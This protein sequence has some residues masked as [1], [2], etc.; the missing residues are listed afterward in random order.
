M[1]LNILVSNFVDELE[2][3]FLDKDLRNLF[4]EELNEYLSIQ[5]Y[6]KDVN[7][8]GIYYII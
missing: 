3:K 1:A 4:G 6:N 5:Q 7:S 2:K 8:K